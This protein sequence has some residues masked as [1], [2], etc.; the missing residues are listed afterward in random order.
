MALGGLKTTPRQFEQRAVPYKIDLESYERV[1]YNIT[2]VIYLSVH[3]QSVVQNIN[4]YLS[5]YAKDKKSV[6]KVLFR[7]ICGRHRLF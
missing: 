4:N 7:T 3:R 5:T 1:Y 2:P 6:L